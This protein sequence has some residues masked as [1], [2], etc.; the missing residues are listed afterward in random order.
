MTQGRQT[1]HPQVLPAQNKGARPMQ[2]PSSTRAAHP[3]SP[4]LWTGRYQL[5]AI[6][7]ALSTLGGCQTPAWQPH[8]SNLKMAPGDRLTINAP[9]P[10]AANTTRRFIQNGQL[11]SR[12]AFERYTP[13]C[14]VEVRALATHKRTLM[15]ADYTVQRIR[16]DEE[17]IAQAHPRH[18]ASLGGANTEF[19]LASEGQGEATMDVVHLYLTPVT[20][21]PASNRTPQ[22]WRLTCAGALSHGSPADHPQSL[23]PDRAQINHILGD[24]ASLSTRHTHPSEGE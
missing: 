22:A 10:I 9:M 23:R 24:W 8:S 13:H 3:T 4:K 18:F 12:H 7:L 21:P 11:T 17:A 1:S 6:V 19:A 16:L 20:P 2:R 5:I 14:R 15:A